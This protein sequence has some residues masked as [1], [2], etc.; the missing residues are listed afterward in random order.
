[1]PN[2]PAVAPHQ[3]KGLGLGLAIVKRLADLMGA[4]LT[5]RSQPGRGTVFT[6]E[7]PVGAQAARRRRPCRAGQGAAR[8][9]AGRP[10]DRGRRGRAGGARGLEVLLQGWGAQ[11]ASFD[12]VAESQRLGRGAPTRRACGPTC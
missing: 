2:T 1:M 10:A 7:L 12:S 9:H 6:L 5:L 4:P 8:A 3:R 11:I